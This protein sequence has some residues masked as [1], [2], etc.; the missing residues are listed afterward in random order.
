MDT[1]FENRYF[2]TDQ[3]LSEYIYKALLK[4]HILIAW[5]GAVGAGV[6]LPF[7]L[8][9]GDQVGAAIFGIC[10]LLMLSL[11]VFSPILVLRQFKETT[12]RINNGQ[13]CETV[14][15]FSDNISISEGT[16][17]LTVEYSQILKIHRLTHSYVLMFAKQN[18]IMISPKHF[19]TGTL[20]NFETFISQ[21]VELRK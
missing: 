15:T 5:I 18:G 4:K 8:Y 21:K 10:L 1:Q 20:E 12:K 9:R 16:F 19:T 11:A 17:S 13:K 14:V 2:S 3:M 6:L 7:E